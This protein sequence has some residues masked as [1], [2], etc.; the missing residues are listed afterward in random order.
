MNA[1]SETWAPAGTP[2]IGACVV[3]N[4]EGWLVTAGHMIDQFAE[5]SQANNK[6]LES[7]A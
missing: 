4:D 5:M 2:S 1:E 7:R 3:V 6:T